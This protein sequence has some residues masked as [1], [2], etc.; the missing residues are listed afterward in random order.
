MH[1]ILCIHYIKSWG[2]V[3]GH[4]LFDG[5]SV[6]AARPYLHGLERD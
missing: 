4:I 3:Q 6:V 1:P 5:G 2:I